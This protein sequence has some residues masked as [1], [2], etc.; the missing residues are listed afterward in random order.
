MDR[1]LFRSQRKAVCVDVQGVSETDVTK[2]PSKGG[3]LG[4]KLFLLNRVQHAEQ[5]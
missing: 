1:L 4:L 3:E 5:H 2:R